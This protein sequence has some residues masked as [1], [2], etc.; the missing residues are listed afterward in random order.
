MKLY[1]GRRDV[2]R[3]TRGA[4]LSLSIFFGASAKT[5][6]DLAGYF[7]TLTQR[8]VATSDHPPNHPHRPVCL[9]LHVFAGEV[10]A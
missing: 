9:W 5:V 3:A 1:L 8:R 10:L 4:V 6:T 2:V 7:A